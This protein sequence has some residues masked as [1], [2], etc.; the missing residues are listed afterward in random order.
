MSQIKISEEEHII[1]SSDDLRQQFDKLYEKKE[2]YR[3]VTLKY[4]SCCGCGC[5]TVEIRRTVPMN[6]FL[7]DGDLVE[8]L[9]KDDEWV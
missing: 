8:R 5:N 6:S 9:E 7:K 1:S 4:K 3:V 2:E